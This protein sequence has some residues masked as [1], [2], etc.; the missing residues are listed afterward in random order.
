MAATLVVASED[1]T[2]TTPPP[3]AP[4]GVNATTFVLDKFSND[5][6]GGFAVEWAVRVYEGLLDTEW[7]HPDYDGGK[8]FEL[9]D[10]EL[11]TGLSIGAGGGKALFKIMA[12]VD[13]RRVGKPAARVLKLMTNLGYTRVVS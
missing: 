4:Q 12:K 13:R 11:L 3:L 1:M 6:E 9:D 5:C 8:P 7:S 2:T 10:Q